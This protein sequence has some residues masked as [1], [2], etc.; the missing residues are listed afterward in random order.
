ML[1]A[2]LVKVGSETFA[3]PLSSVVEVV[4]VD[5]AQLRR[6]GRLMQLPLRNDALTYADLRGVLRIDTQSPPTV[7]VVVRFGAE[8]MAFAVDAA[9]RQAD[10]VVK[11]LSGRLRRVPGVAGVAESGDDRLMVVLDMGALMQDALRGVRVVA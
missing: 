5:E 11:P 2:L 3:V 8:R 1:R 10:I 7:A 4:P 6:R 9:L